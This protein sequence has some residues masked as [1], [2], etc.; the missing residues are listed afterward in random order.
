MK[1]QQDKK[2]HL[3]ANVII[4]IIASVIN[5]L[6]IILNF[7]LFV[8]IGINIFMIAIG[9][10]IGKEVGDYFSPSSKWDW[11]DIL[12]DGIGALSTSI[13]LS[14]LIGLYLGWQ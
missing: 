3:I 10:S 4:V 8:I 6:M 2:L 11:A 12:W 9:T 14:T 13:V 5:F 1:M 7:P